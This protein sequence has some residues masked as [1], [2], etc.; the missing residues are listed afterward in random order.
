ML[1]TPRQSASR[2]SYESNPVVDLD[3]RVI[4]Q[5]IRQAEVLCAPIASTRA[6]GFL[7]CLDYPSTPLCLLLPAFPRSRL[8]EDSFLRP[9]RQRQPS[10]KTRIC[11]GSLPIRSCERVV[12]RYRTRRMSSRGQKTSRNL[13]PGIAGRLYSP[14]HNKALWSLP[15][16]RSAASRSRREELNRKARGSRSVLQGGDV[17]IVIV[18]IIFQTP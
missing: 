4:S 9:C 18:T 16:T 13:A 2:R 5:I 6:A 17:A 1:R 3:P 8:R 10:I 7:E 12:S 15:R 14:S 11:Q